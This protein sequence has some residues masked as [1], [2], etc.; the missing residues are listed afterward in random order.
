MLLI[1][2]I[3]YGTYRAESKDNYVSNKKQTLK[4]IPAAGRVGGFIS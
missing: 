1:D 3:V 2:T 4:T